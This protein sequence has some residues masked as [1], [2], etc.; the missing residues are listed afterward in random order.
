MGAAEQKSDVGSSVEKNG[1]LLEGHVGYAE[2]EIDEHSSDE[3]L[4]RYVINPAE[5][6]VL[7]RRLDLVL[8]PLVCILVI[9]LFP[10]HQVHSRNGT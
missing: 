6:K 1:D 9:S 7:L 8:G 2:Q 10:F 3:E 4:V 5:Q